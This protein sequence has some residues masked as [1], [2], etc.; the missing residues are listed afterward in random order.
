[1]SLV[2]F[3]PSSPT[4]EAP[5]IHTLDWDDVGASYP[6]RLVSTQVYLTRL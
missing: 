3:Q 4:V 6:V 1:M 2:R 5:V